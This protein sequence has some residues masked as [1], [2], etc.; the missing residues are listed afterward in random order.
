MIHVALLYFIQEKP[1]KLRSEEFADILTLATFTMIIDFRL[2]LLW[3]RS[4][5]TLHT[6]LFQ[7]MV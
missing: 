1:V 3:S 4:K 7:K 6:H 2:T 5:N